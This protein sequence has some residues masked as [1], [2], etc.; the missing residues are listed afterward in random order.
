MNTPVAL[1]VYKRPETTRRVLAAVAQARPKTLLVVADGPR[2]GR[3]GEAERCAAARALLSDLAW[4]C[5]LLTNYA[6]QNL[7]CRRRLASGLDWVFSLV[8]EAIILE[9][10][11]LPHRDFFA[12]CS[13]LLARYRENERVMHIGGANYQFGRRHGSASYYFSRYPHIWGWASWRRA[14]RHYD[15]EMTSGR[16]TA[17]R[18]ALL[19][20]LSLPERRFWRE[21]WD[22]V[23]AGEIDSW[24]YQWVLACFARQALAIVPNANLVSNIGFDATATHTRKAHVTANLPLEELDWP[25]VHA[26]SLAHCHEADEH[27]SQMLFSYYSPG[28]LALRRI[29][30]ALGLIERVRRPGRP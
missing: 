21:R 22:R 15:V 8:E 23:S 3:I 7:G 25:L 30:K 28:E 19:E 24:D 16:N 27:L 4:P 6:D 5:E 17:D 18:G 1:F 10:D 26:D 11:C 13:E 9:D 29:G 14:W 20:A 12:F 2:P